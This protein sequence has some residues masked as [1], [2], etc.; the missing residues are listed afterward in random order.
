M[1]DIERITIALPTPMADLVRAAVEAG[2][3]ASASEVFRDALRLWDARRELR[4]RDLDLLRDRWD[5]GRASGHAGEIDPA[6]L[7]ADEKARRA[8]P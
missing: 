4:A 1:A 7:L 8:R 6:A 2:E 3:Y 5:S